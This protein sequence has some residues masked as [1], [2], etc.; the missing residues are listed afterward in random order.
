MKDKK[1]KYIQAV[2]N[3]LKRR[4]TVIVNADNFSSEALN[5]IYWFY[6]NNGLKTEKEQNKPSKHEIYYLTKIFFNH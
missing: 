6:L 2:I 1:K 3:V 5:S 4:S